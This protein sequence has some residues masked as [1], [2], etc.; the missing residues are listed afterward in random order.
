MLTIGKVFLYDLGELKD[1]YR[2][3]SLVGLAFSLILVSLAYQR[4]VFRRR[5]ATSRTDQRD[6][7]VSAGPAS[8]LARRRSRAARGAPALAQPA[9]ISP[10]CSRRRRRSRR[11]SPGRLVRLDLPA[12]VLAAC[13]AD[14]SDL[15]VFDAAGREVPFVIESGVAGALRGATLEAV[16]AARAEMLEAQP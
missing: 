10:R 5:P 2:V 12:E 7:G 15:R 6:E 13:R 16:T 14:L 1:L 4:F 8:A 9:A 11:R 3:A